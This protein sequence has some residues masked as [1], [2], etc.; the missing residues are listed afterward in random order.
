MPED[1]VR[2]LARMQLGVAT[3]A[4][5]LQVARAADG[6]PLRRKMS[7]RSD[8]LAVTAC[9]LSVIAIVVTVVV[10]A[11]TLNNSQ[12]IDRT[13]TAGVKAICAVVSYAE[14][15]APIIRAGMRAGMRGRTGSPEAADRLEKLARDMRKTGISCPPAAKRTP[16]P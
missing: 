16:L 10:G 4:D 3:T 11:T 9:V 15:Q 7:R 13:A 5:E 2:A 1:A 8:H 6:A 14:E 12:R